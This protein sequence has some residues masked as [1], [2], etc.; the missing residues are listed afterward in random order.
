MKKLIVIGVLAMA[1]FAMNAQSYKES[2]RYWDEGPLTWDDL[3]LKTPKDYKTCDL[4]FRWGIDNKKERISWNTVQYTPLPR[5]SLD[6]SVSWH[7]AERVYPF[8]LTYDQ[9]LFDLNELYFRKML[10]ELY[11]KDNETSSNELYSFYSNQN[12]V[13]W[14]EIEED[15]EDGM[16]ST[17]VAY[18]ASEIV[19]EL[20]SL[21]YPDILSGGWDKH[22][23]VMSFGAA[24]NV[25]AGS[26]SETFSPAY[27][28]DLGLYTGNGRHEFMGMVSFSSGSCLKDFTYKDKTLK[29]G[30][31]FNHMNL[32][33]AYGYMAYDGNVFSVMPFAGVGL[34]GISWTIKDDTD[35]QS[36]AKPESGD[37]TTP[38]PL[39][40]LESRFKFSRTV[41][42]V[43]IL[44]HGLYLRAYASRDFGL[45]NAFSFNITLGYC[46]GVK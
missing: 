38:V 33:F 23:V 19:E 3:T 31:S 42:R 9:L 39:I 43:S 22:L 29:S 1:C 40:G 13:R 37:Y 20:A 27:G 35:S 32:A 26:A 44:E 41:S 12:R 15:T 5:V 30:E 46:Y 21:H 11:S 10:T 2:M 7:N 8:T 16:D 6:K 17:K 18:Y 28:I 36:N 34:R 4:T 14:G 24:G 25:F 45:F